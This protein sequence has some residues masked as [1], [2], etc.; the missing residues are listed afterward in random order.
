MRNYISLS[1]LLLLLTSCY[2]RQEGCLDIRARNY[3]FTADDSCDDCCDF[4]IMKLGVS[5]M[6]GDTTLMEDSIY[7]NSFNQEIQILKAQFLLSEISLSDGLDS[8]TVSEMIDVVD[9]NGNTLTLPSNFALIDTDL[10]NYS[11]GSFE[12]AKDY[13]RLHMTFGIDGL[14]TND[15]VVDENGFFDEE[16]LTYTNFKMQYVFNNDTSL[17]N[18]IGP[19][20]SLPLEF[21]GFFEL[22]IGIDFVIPLSVDY[23]KLFEGIDFSKLGSEETDQMIIDNIIPFFS[24]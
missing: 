11:V 18:L 20:N 4:P 12:K 13:T 21:D 14:F 1:F 5:H 19:S 22:P 7:L 23:Q 15:G 6:W 10:F 17:Y 3:D 2:E 24:S 16:T 8:E 9:I